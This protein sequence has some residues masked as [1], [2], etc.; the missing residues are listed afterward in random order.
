VNSAGD[1]VATVL[2]PSGCDSA[3]VLYHQ[4]QPPKVL[5]TGCAISIT[6]RAFANNGD[7]I[8]FLENNGNHFYIHHADGTRTLVVQRGDPIGSSVVG[9]LGRAMLKANGSAAVLEIYPAGSSGQL[10]FWNGSTFQEMAAAG[11]FVSVGA[12]TNY[13]FPVESGTG[14]IYCR[15][16]LTTGPAVTHYTS[17]TWKLVAQA[18]TIVGN[19][20]LWW[21]YQI[22]AAGSDGSIAV[23]ADSASGTSVLRLT[24]GNPDHLAAVQ[25]SN[26]VTQLAGGGSGVIDSGLIAG[27]PGVYL[28]ASGKS[29]SPLLSPGWQVPTPGNVSFQWDN[30]PERGLASSPLM[31]QPGD[32]LVRVNAG[33]LQAVAGTGVSAGGD[34][35]NWLGSV[36]T[37]PDGKN[38]VFSANTSGNN[39]FLNAHDGRVDLIGDITNHPI[40]TGGQKVSWID[41]NWSGPFAMN[42]NQFVALAN[43]GSQSTLMR[44]DLAAAQV[45]PII[46]LQQPSPAGAAYNWVSSAAIDTAGDVAFY[47]GLTDGNSALFL[48]KN[49]QVQKL[50]R[51]G[52]ASLQGGQVS[53]ISNSV[54][55]A[56]SNVVDLVWYQNTGS[57]IQMFDGTAWTLVATS[58][59]VLGSG[60]TI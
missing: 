9:S 11:G 41:P 4:G 15:L 27:K 48:W 59:T 14:E 26:N 16:T 60:R 31:R 23:L 29:P 10:W 25:S 35:V 53:G 49:G 5:D 44:L 2:F 46:T 47:G 37:S 56:G 22:S 19:T 38:A 12:V 3:I 17:G 57:K 34:V 21:F 50:L 28:L 18:N 54:W 1:V 24:S 51:T 33:A 42:T 6:D 8:Y 55:F 32:Q 7:V 36:V 30:V 39:A 40:L 52:D 58:G 45:T 13:D 43:V 20:Q